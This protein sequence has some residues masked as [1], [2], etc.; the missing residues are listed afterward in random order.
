MQALFTQLFIRLLNGISRL[1]WDAL[2]R[3]SDIFRFLIFDVGQYRKQVVISNLERSFPAY[4]QDK[5]QK[6]ARQFYRNFTDIIFETIKLKSIS[7]EDLYERVYVE[8]PILRHFY[9]QNRDIIV[10]AGHLGNWEM[11][12]LRASSN[13]FYHMVVVY[14]E[15]ANDAFENWFHRV[16]TRFGTE[17]V[18]MKEAMS[19]AQER[20]DKP[21]IFILINDQSPVPEKAYWTKFLNQDTG[22]FRGVEAMAKRLDAP[23]LYM[24]I[25]R[26][27]AKRGYYRTKFEVITENPKE[28]PANRIIQMQVKF[29]ERDITA[30]PDNW[31]WSHRRWKHKRPARL[32]PNQRLQEL[33]RE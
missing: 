28:E 19:K 20:R 24:G 2:Y 4:S 8:E 11:L 3:I 16:R 23:V 10:V 31:L 30:Q 13:L 15:L 22:I 1:S 6:I 17:M 33:E 14:H 12:N 25:F 9:D 18:T 27:I 7:A 26:D 32:L 21:T 5:I 29:L